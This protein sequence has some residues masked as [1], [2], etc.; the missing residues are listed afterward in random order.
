MVRI[1]LRYLPICDLDHLEQ[2][3]NSMREMD[4]THTILACIQ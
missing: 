1:L 3:E 2:R 4:F